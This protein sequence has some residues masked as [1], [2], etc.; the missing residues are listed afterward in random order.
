MFFQIL[1]LTLLISSYSFI[2]YK[3]RSSNFE[4]ISSSITTKLMA[5]MDETNLSADELKAELELRNVDYSNCISRNELVELLIETRME[6]KADKEIL[7]KFNEM[8]KDT[9]ANVNK[10]E[11]FSNENVDQVIGKDGNLPGGLPPELAKAMIDDPAIAEMLRDPKTQDIMKAVMEGGPE[12]M[13]KYLSDPDA[14]LLLQKL[15]QA[16]ERVKD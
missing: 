6:G 13:K 16:I 15:G 14:M 12:A 8:D 11:T 7:D 1:I 2:H 4:R 3:H 9:S 5:G 10:E